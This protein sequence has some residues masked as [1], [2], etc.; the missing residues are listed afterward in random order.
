MIKKKDNLQ[1]NLNIFLIIVATLVA[2][3]LVFIYSSSC[4][5]AMEKFSSA[6]Y[7]V[8]KQAF[9]LILGLISILF[10]FILPLK[11]IKKITPYLF[12]GS[13]ALT[14]ATMIPGIAQRIHGSARWINLFGFSFQPSE[15]LKISVILYI[16]YF[17]VKKQDK[18]N[19]F[20]NA[21]LPV[22]VILGITSVILLKQPDFGLTVTI[23][24]TVFTMLFVAKFNS[25][26]LI[27]TFAA[28]IPAAATLVLIKPYRLQR[29]LTFLNPWQD[30]Q[31]SGFQIIQSLIAIGSGGLWGV[32]IA[33]S[34]QKFFYLPMQHTD[35]IFSIIAE[36][37][38]LIGSLCIITLFTALLFLGIRIS[39]S[40]KDIF[41]KFT[42]L[43]LVI[44]ISIQAII[45]LSVA[46]G[47][48]PTKGIGLPFVSYGNTSL[49]CTL[50]MVGLIINIVYSNIYEKISN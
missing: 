26:Y 27:L 2:I 1:A 6:Q 17:I 12:W 43:G 20:F 11:F 42:V 49:V 41:S 24:S 10:V 8:K 46:A 25:K 45:N 50:C 35:F 14:S 18:L 36:E 22:L 37:T 9:G 3:G 23:V 29:I 34:K 47:L 38:G 19:S 21:Y 48:A 33:N 31:G 28:L 30:P 4:V 44:L 5:Y 32:G 39:L 16:A 15:I 7:F 40:L 13:L